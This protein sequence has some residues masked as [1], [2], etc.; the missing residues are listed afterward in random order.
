M[1]RRV[2]VCFV[3]F[4]IAILMVAHPFPEVRNCAFSQEQSQE[5]KAALKERDRLAKKSE[6]L[7]AGGKLAEVIAAAKAMLAIERKVLPADHDDV[8]GSLNWL[9]VCAFIQTA[10]GSIRWIM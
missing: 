5:A 9:G 8:I 1:I 3:T 4:G 10:A 7:E 2:H 6:E